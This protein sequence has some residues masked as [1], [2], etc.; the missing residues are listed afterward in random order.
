MKG[1]RRE[2]ET[3]GRGI[4]REGKRYRKCCGS[5]EERG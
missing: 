3:R 1:E 5:V 2:W 4:K